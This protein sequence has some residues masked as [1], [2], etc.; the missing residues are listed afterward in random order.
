MKSYAT[1]LTELIGARLAAL[2]VSHPLQVTSSDEVA[3]RRIT[4]APEARQEFGADIVLTGSLYRSGG[5]FVVLFSLLDPETSQ[6]LRVETL[7]MNGDGSLA[8]EGRILTATL[9]TVGLSLTEAERSVLSNQGTNSGAAFDL[10]IEGKGWLNDAQNAEDIQKAI[11]LFERALQAD[12]NYADAYAA[13]GQAYWRRY[14]LTKDAIS[15]ADARRNCDQAFKLNS[16]LAAAQICLG[17]INNGTGQYQ[18]AAIEFEAAVKLDPANDAAY[19]G[20]ARAQEGL[21]N[22]HLSTVDRSASSLLGRLL[23]AGALLYPSGTIRRRGDPIEQSDH[24]VTR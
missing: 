3:A 2:T 6:R 17:T 7:S 18:Q 12:S 21:G 14:Q 9:E 5:R 20:L 1:G 11:S 23:V 10:Y 24:D 4:T 19:E 16:Q 15:I 8:G 13:L 22:T